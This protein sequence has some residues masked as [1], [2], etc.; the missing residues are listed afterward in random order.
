MY[1]TI[2]Y[3]CFIQVHNF[4]QWQV[5]QPGSTIDVYV[6]ELEAVLQQKASSIA[7]LQRRLRAFRDKLQEEEVI[8][9]SVSKR[10]VAA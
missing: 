8:S 10:R 6:E 1:K 2:L 3:I 5:D 4:E 7:T 9:Q